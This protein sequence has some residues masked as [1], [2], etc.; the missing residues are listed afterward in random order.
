[1]PNFDMNNKKKKKVDKA[2]GAFINQWIDIFVFSEVMIW[3]TRARVRAEI[4][5]LVWSILFCTLK[6][7]IPPH[8]APFLYK[9]KRFCRFKCSNVDLKFKEKSNNWARFGIHNRSCRKVSVQIDLQ[10]QSRDLNHASSPCYLAPL[11]VTLMVINFKDL[12]EIECHLSS[13]SFTLLF[14]NATTLF[15]L[16]ALRYALSMEEWWEK[17][18][19]EKRPVFF[20]LPVNPSLDLYPLSPI[21]LPQSIGHINI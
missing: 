12:T 6:K 4:F 1:M 13:F 10:K 16:I 19:Q 11:V 18:W 14:V 3:M 15:F 17:K 7:P 9:F 21:I 20:L 8:W 5:F 2:Q